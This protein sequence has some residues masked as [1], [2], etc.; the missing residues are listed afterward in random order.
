MNERRTAQK[1][2]ITILVSG[3]MLAVLW[4]Y[5]AHWDWNTYPLKI[6]FTDTRGLQIQAPVLMNG[7]KIGEVKDI[8]LDLRTRQPIVTLRLQ[9]K[10]ESGIPVD[11]RVMI[12]TGLLVS[13]PQIEVAPG[14]SSVMMKAGRTYRGAD[15]E[16]MLSQISPE[17]DRVVKQFSTAMEA[18]TPRLDRSMEHIEGILKRTEV[19]MGDFGVVSNRARHLASDPQIERTLRS[20]LRDLQVISSQ[21]R[22]TTVS[23]GTELES[24]M[25]RS[26]GRVD[27]LMTGLFDLL[28]RFTDTVDAARSLVSRLSEQVNNPRLQ[29]SLQETLELTRATIARFNQVASDIHALLGDAEVQSDLKT[30]LAS[31]RDATAS[32][33]K[34]AEDVSRLV[35]RLGSSS[36]RPSFG[37]GQ[38]GLSIE[39]GGRSS[40]PYFRSNIGLR[41]PMG[42]NAFHLGIYDLAETNKL[43]AQY[44]TRTGL[45]AFRYGL[46]ASKLGVG[47]D[48][49]LPYGVQLRLDAHNPNQLQVDSRA[50]IKLNSDFSLWVGVDGWLRH[51]TPT[52]GLRLER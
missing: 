2:G 6:R 43:T 45:G 28:Q 11:S 44:E 40:H 19:M 14:R 34:V 16:S 5:L 4:S 10:Y 46:Y 18:M 8:E 24:L 37:I 36:T 35:D 9:S 39:M 31:V 15:P 27:D 22:R 48:T 33:K 7:V 52:I 50:F 29:Q 49:P 21:A 38:P 32:G 23:F 41:F 13:S 26:G 17:T 12:T 51:A 1:V 30:T 20:S 25:A 42:N 3:V 47:L